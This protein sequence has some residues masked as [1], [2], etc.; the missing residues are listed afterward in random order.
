MTQKA[1]TKMAG[2]K[3]HQ[4]R[5]TVFTQVPKVV[6]LKLFGLVSV[7]AGFAAVVRDESRIQQER[8]AEAER[9]GVNAFAYRQSRDTGFPVFT[10]RQ[11][12]IA[13][14]QLVKELRERGLV[15]TGGHYH[16][17]GADRVLVHTLS[18]N[19]AGEAD[20]DGKVYA[21]QPIPAA[22]VTALSEMEWSGTTWANLKSPETGPAFR[23]DTINLSEGEPAK[24]APFLRME[25]NTYRLI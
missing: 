8:K 13:I 21:E 19:K 24:S 23:L 12:R 1:S 22:L 20:P 5:M 7:I 17:Q 18:F 11:V 9:K 10:K 2:S 3:D 16:Y 25:G 14:L 15:F 4:K 6:L